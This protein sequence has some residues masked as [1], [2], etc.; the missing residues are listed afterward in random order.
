MP[1]DLVA[2]ALKRRLFV[3]VPAAPVH[4]QPARLIDGD[5]VFVGEQDPHCAQVCDKRLRIGRP[6]PLPVGSTR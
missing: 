5:V 6:G 2:N 1:T 4:E 3:T